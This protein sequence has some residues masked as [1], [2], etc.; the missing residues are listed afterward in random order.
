MYDSSSPD[1]MHFCKMN[2]SCKQQVQS[3]CVAGRGRGVQRGGV[4]REDSGASVGGAKQALLKN[5]LP[6][7]MG[8]FYREFYVA[9]IKRPFT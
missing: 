8:N 9:E 6:A 7:D 1:V 4:G 3:P 2:Q 5:F